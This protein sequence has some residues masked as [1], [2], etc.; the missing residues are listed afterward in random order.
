MT[1]TVTQ[2][3]GGRKNLARWLL[4]LNGKITYIYTVKK[5]LDGE[6]E[7][8]FDIIKQWNS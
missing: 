2:K 8:D 6:V 1:V 4:Y 5:W 3:D 7:L